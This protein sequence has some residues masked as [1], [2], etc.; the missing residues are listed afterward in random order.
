M[1][2]VLTRALIN[3]GV[4]QMAHQ[5]RTRRAW[6]AIGAT[7]VGVATV[8]TVATTGTA[9]ADPTSLVTS[10]AFPVGAY[11]PA[12]SPAGT[13]NAACSTPLQGCATPLVA[14]GVQLTGTAGFSEGGI[15]SAAPVDTT[16]GLDVSFTTNQSGGN[17][18][19]GITFFMSTA[20]G[21]ITMGAPGG[22][23]GYGADQNGLDLNGQTSPTS[24][25][26]LHGLSGAYLGVGLDT[27]GNWPT[28]NYSGETCD[29][30]GLPTTRQPGSVAVRGPGGG[31]NGY[32]LINSSKPNLALGGSN[33]PVEVVVNT[34]GLPQ[35]PTSAGATGVVPNGDFGV[36]VPVGGTMTEVSSGLL[37]STVPALTSAELGFTASTGGSNDNHAVSGISVSPLVAPATN[38]VFTGEP[39]STTTDPSIGNIV[40]QA[41]SSNNAVDT[42][43]DGPVSLALSGGTAGASL[44]GTTTVNAVNGVATFG[45]LS[46]GTAGTGYI[47]T[48]S[49]TTPGIT[50]GQ[51]TPFDVAAVATNCAANST[52]TAVLPATGTNPTTTIVA[53][54]A[55]SG[56]VEAFYGA[57]AVVYN[58]KSN[59]ASILTFSGPGVRKSITLNLTGVTPSIASVL[60]F[61]YGQPTPFL[62][63][64]LKTTTFR[65]QTNDNEYEGIL[66]VC[67]PNFPKI[68]PA[69]NPCF[70][71]TALNLKAGTET[72]VIYSG[73]GASDPRLSRS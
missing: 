24:D 49:T 39:N 36:W 13:D 60:K 53:P 46:V 55:T 41:E 50:A 1:R 2:R 42:L 61:C 35:S 28:A 68:L 37:P 73:L 34:T 45:P 9:S 23:L 18:A 70:T 38:L 66:P 5:K 59:L 71:I 31:L 22:H 48:A 29:N 8:G 44:S 33:V 12:G 26:L 19:D 57:P 43:Y 47:L 14:T 63:F 54:G 58:C 17:G 11:A 62:D 51:S 56:T 30:T 20:A 65:N 52:C 25:G 15:V 69:S 7:L 32:C 3:M 16:R 72:A 67:L 21:T 4:T 64:T 40:V 6:I 27:Y 10:W